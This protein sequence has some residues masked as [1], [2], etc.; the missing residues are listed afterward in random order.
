M[1]DEDNDDDD[2][3]NGNRIIAKLIMNIMLI[4]FA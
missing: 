4:C 1:I 2:D 3:G